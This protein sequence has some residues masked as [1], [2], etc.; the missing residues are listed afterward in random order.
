MDPL[1]P[2]CKTCDSWDQAG[3]STPG[4]GVCHRMA[5]FGDAVHTRS[6]FGCPFHSDFPT[7]RTQRL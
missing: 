7:M 2:T 6:R 5:L 3:S 4:L 1:P